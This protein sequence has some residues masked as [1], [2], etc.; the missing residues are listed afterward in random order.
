PHLKEYFLTVRNMLG[1]DGVALVHSISTKSPPGVTGPFIR[2][3]I[4]PNGYSPALS[5][6]VA[7]I[8]PTGLWVLDVEVWRKHYGF[9]LNE[10]RKRF[11]ER[12]DEA[13]AMYDERFARMWEFYL[14]ASEGVFMYGSSCVVQLQIGRQRDGVP[15][16]RDY[17]YD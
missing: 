1:P 11:A 6:I 13:V 15:L 14:A 8:E 3:Y 9:T 4:F 12:R 5:E 7:A 10:W 16:S 17:M 2:K